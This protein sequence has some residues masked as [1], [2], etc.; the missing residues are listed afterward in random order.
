MSE[1][2]P[3]R[4]RSHIEKTLMLNED[5][6]TDDFSGNQGQE[7]GGGGA[8][9]VGVGR[10]VGCVGEDLGWAGR[11]LWPAA[12]QH[13]AGHGCSSEA[14]RHPREEERPGDGGLHG[15]ARAHHPRLEG[16]GLVGRRKGDPSRGTSE[17]VE[18]KSQCCC[19]G[20]VQPPSH[21]QEGLFITLALIFFS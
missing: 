4:D 16:S 7:L 21:G 10:G 6:P 1:E 11:A 2:A 9:V 17:R 12:T 3:L 19:L 13:L 5:K 14:S 15:E 20:T 8:G 18:G